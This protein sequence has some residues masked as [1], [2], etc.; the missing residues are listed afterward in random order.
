VTAQRRRFLAASDGLDI[1]ERLAQDASLVRAQ[2]G[3]PI[4]QNG[5]AV[6]VQDGGDLV[7]GWVA[8]TSVS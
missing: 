1:A 2:R 7:G 5:I 6:A 3:E 8:K 4:P